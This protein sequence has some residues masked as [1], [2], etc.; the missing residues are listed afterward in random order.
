M[1]ALRQKPKDLSSEKKLE[2]FLTDLARYRDVSATDDE[3]DSL[4][5]DL[6]VFAVR[7][8]TLRVELPEGLPCQIGLQGGE[9]RRLF[10]WKSAPTVLLS[11]R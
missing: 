7:P 5:G 11:G 8:E 9:G 4:L 1:T 3:R 10:F 2:Q 6:G